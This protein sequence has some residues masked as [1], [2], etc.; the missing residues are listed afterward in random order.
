MARRLLTLLLLL[1]AAAVHA[2]W[3]AASAQE[4]ALDAAAFAGVR[5][6]LAQQLTDVQAVV[7]ALQGRVV[8]AWHRDGA[9]DTLRETQS[10]N[11]SALSALVGA[12]IGEG[13]IASVDQ[14]VL[15]ILPEWQALNADPRTA[16]IT[17]RHLLTMSAG[18]AFE[19]ATGTGAPGRPADG[20]ARPL[21]HAPGTQFQ[22]D[23][24]SVAMLQAVLE[25]ATG[26]P[27]PEYARSH[28]VQPLGMAE[29]DYRR[30]LRLRTEDMA[31]LGQLFLQQGQ[32][33]GRQLLPADYVAAATAP[34]NAGGPPVRMPYGY[35]W[36]VPGSAGERRT[37]MANGFGGQYIWAWPPREVVVA[38]HS[39][40]TRQSNERGHAL[41]LILRHVVP[42]LRQR[43]AAEPR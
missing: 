22:Y 19:D 26:M 2:D 13:R 32:W 15:A 3:R 37:F 36:W 18:F 7:V 6:A 4:Q 12:A 30:M 17:V 5:E 28:L 23:N 35:L 39:D 38:V 1:A 14:P 42:A 25:K 8:F 29:P 34:Q 11:K 27:L 21:R 43:A 16:A 41:Q 24:A 40:P 33:E 9:P 31:R 20:W 10:V